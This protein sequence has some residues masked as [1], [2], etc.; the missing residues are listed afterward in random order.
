MSGILGLM[1]GLVLDSLKN[2]VEGRLWN[3]SDRQARFLS[4]L[5]LMIYIQDHHLHQPK[6]DELSDIVSCIKC[7]SGL[8]HL[9]YRR[10][11]EYSR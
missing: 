5:C 1:A 3:R 11:R 6:L 10:N 2:M 7:S 8:V 9:Q 4:R